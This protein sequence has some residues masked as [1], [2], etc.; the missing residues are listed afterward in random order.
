[1]D[2][3]VEITVPWNATYRTDYLVAGKYPSLSLCT[4]YAQVIESDR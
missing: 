2:G 4:I 3:T 1:M